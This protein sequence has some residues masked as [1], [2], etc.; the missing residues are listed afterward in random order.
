MNGLVILV[1]TVL[2]SMHSS[3][4][5]AFPMNCLKFSCVYTPSFVQ[6]VLYCWPGEVFPVFSLLQ[7]V[8]DEQLFACVFSCLPVCFWNRF[9]G[10]D[11][12]DQVEHACVICQVFPESPLQS[13]LLLCSQNQQSIS[14]QLVCLHSCQHKFLGFQ[15]PAT[16]IGK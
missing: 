6:P 9:P 1:Q 16:F 15:I 4:K 7:S 14:L 2:K 13:I 3:S 10:L 5:R 8:A 11:W 12:L